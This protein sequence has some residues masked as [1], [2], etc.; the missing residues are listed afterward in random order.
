MKFDIIRQVHRLAWITLLISAGAPAQTATDSPVMIGEGS[1]VAIEF[2]I[3]LED[4]SVFGGNE[5]DTPLEYEQGDGR[6]PPGLETALVGLKADDR[7]KVTLSPE[8]GYGPVNPEAFS[9][10]A[11]ERIPSEARRTGAILIV[12]DQNGNRRY[13]RVHEVQ[14]EKV[15]VDLNHP[16]AGKVV[17]FDVHVL[18][19][20]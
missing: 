14:E 3:Y 1:K 11:I 6:L 12:S 2:T 9:D 4:G 17:T 10:V 18:T 5:G 16:L 8:Q 19:V 20:E 15:I 7:K 13:V